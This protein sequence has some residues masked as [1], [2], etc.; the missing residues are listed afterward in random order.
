MSQPKTARQCAERHCGRE[1][2][3]VGLQGRPHGGQNRY[4]SLDNTCDETVNVPRCN[5]A[6]C[7]K[8]PGS[9]DLRSYVPRICPNPVLPD[10]V[11]HATV[12]GRHQRWVSRIDPTGGRGVDRIANFASSAGSPKDHSRPS[13]VGAAFRNTGGTDMFTR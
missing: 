11:H 7:R 1:T 6:P 12:G 8:A 9:T 13:G 5:S 3:K 4:V 2:P 10:S